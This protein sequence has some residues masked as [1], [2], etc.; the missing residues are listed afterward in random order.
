MPSPSI[1]GI[2]SKVSLNIR[3]CLLVCIHCPISLMHNLFWTGK[4][5]GL[6]CVFQLV[7]SWLLSQWLLLLKWYVTAWVKKPSTASCVVD[8][9]P[10]CLPQSRLLERL[11]QTKL[12]SRFSMKGAVG[13]V[14]NRRRSIRQGFQRTERRSRF[15]NDRAG[16]TEVLRG[17]PRNQYCPPPAPPTAQTTGL[18]QP[19]QLEQL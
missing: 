2:L 13:E 3:L 19:V 15:S 6:C 18:N 11:Q 4:E 17:R 1:I 16:V 14:F 7:S 10:S 8:A 9:V 5:F 12:R